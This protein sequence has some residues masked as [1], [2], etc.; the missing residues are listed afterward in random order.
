[1]K[2]KRTINYKITKYE[3]YYLAGLID[4]SSSFY[5]TKQAC[6]RKNEL[7]KNS[8]RWV[9]AFVIQSVNHKLIEHISHLL[10]LG[11]SHTHTI[12][13][14]GN[15]HNHRLLKAIRVTGPILDYLLPELI[16]ILKVKQQHA[17]ILRDFRESVTTV[18]YDQHNPVPLE[19]EIYR[20]ELSNKV[21]YLNSK[22][23]KDTIGSPLLPSA[24]KHTNCK[25]QP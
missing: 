7:G 23:Y 21:S 14:K 25:E 17:Q 12:D 4:S 9:C 15:G 16:P 2:N 24:N 1:M 3:F 6:G 8:L 20:Q 19:V 18:R 22:E 13:L 5:L 11:D 10:F